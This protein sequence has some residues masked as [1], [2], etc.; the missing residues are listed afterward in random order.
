M[1]ISFDFSKP[2][3]LRNIF[4]AF[5]AFGFS[6]GVLFP[7]FANLFVEWKDGML[8]W[9]IISCIIAG[10]SIGLFNFWLLNKM[11]LQRLKRIGE[12]ANAISQNDVSHTCGLQSADFIGDMASSFNM[13]A[14]NLR[15]MINRIAD[16][17]TELNSA[18][19]DMVQETQMTQ[20]GV[21]R[22]KQDTLHVATAV[23]SM[24]QAVMEMSNHAQD[25]LNSVNEANIA[26]ERGTNVVNQTVE[27]ISNLA[28]Q[29][30]NAADVI[31]RLERDSE[32]I[33]SVLDVIKDIAEQTNLL[34]LNAAIEAARAGEHGRGFAVVADEV[35]ILASRT[36]ESTTEIEATIAQLQVA[37]QQAV[38]AMNQGREKATQTVGHAH[39]AGE[40]LKA[41][42]TA[43]SNINRMNSQISGA[44][45]K[46][47]EQAQRVSSNVEQISAVAEQVANGA[48]QTMQSSAQVGEISEQLS[49]LIGQFK[50][51]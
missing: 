16:V 23:E 22:Q 48:A 45:D 19:A 43:V 14:G 34:A 29:V 39:E 11:L 46:Q 41:I 44:S 13:M 10:I 51:K 25:A 6:M 4:L 18:S 1:M 20:D 5:M 7:V 9:F 26:T 28:D 17:S 38:E 27:S 3:I 8:I 15:L 24:N 30:A 50:T 12:V 2:S 33:G 32:T 47:R 21:E 42:E 35:R 37:S 31:K 40:S 49:K 36:Q